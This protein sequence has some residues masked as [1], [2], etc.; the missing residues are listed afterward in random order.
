MERS[1]S[2]LHTVKKFETKDNLP[3][4]TFQLDFLRRILQNKGHFLEI[5]IDYEHLRAA[6]GEQRCN[7]ILYPRIYLLELTD[8]FGLEEKLHCTLQP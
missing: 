5:R 8:S 3:R 2:C 6:L 1:T 4:D 7:S